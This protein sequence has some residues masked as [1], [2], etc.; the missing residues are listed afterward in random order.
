MLHNHLADTPVKVASGLLVLVGAVGVPAWA[1]HAR[2]PA[3]PT[4]TVACEGQ[5]HDVSGPPADDPTSV[6][7]R[8]PETAIV[9]VSR[10]GRFTAAMSNTGCPPRSGSEIYLVWPDGTITECTTLDAGTVRWAGEF[11]QPGEFE[12]QPDGAM[13][14]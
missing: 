11:L 10:D 4:P 3:A 13:C 8:V 12:P 14:P 1:A 7:V 2:Q 9:Q 5:L 6:V